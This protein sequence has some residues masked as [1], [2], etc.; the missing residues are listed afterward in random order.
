MDADDELADEVE[1][2]MGHCISGE[3]MTAPYDV[4]AG[5]VFPSPAVAGRSESRRPILLSALKVHTV[6]PG[7]YLDLGENA[8]SQ[9]SK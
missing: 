4:V 7:E 3:P 1:E 2:A 8:V 5:E 6:G 9:S